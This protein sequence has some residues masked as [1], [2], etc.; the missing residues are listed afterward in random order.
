MSPLLF[1]LIVE[2]LNILINNTNMDNRIEG[3]KIAKFIKVTHLLFVDDVVLF[4]KSTLAEW[5]AFKSIVD[6]FIRATWMEAS[7]KKS[8][9]LEF[10]ME[11]STKS[12][13]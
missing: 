10:G 6:L 12:H 4:G 3:I 5:I 13:L 2:G 9:F 11:V 1:L 7:D 8:I